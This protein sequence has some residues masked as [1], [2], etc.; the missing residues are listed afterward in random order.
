MEAGNGED[1]KG[2]KRLRGLRGEQWRWGSWG[3]GGNQNWGRKT[4]TVMIFESQ[5]LHM[6]NRKKQKRATA[7]QNVGLEEVE[8]VWGTPISQEA[9]E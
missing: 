4:K 2:G 5:C 3:R 6:S 8:K 7:K 9:K 1:L